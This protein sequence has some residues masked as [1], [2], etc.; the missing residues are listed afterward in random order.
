MLKQEFEQLA[1]RSVTDDQFKAINDLY[2]Q[3]DL[4]K[5][6]FVKSIKPLLATIKE[7]EKP[8]LSC[9]MIRHNSAG[10]TKTPNGCWYLTTKVQ[11]VDVDIRKGKVF[12]RKI[13]DSFEMVSG[14]YDEN[15]VFNDWDSRIV[16]V[17][18]AD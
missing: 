12:L 6:A 18:E 3:S 4:D 5:L 2:M 14:F 9:Y 13:P 7:I 16:F 10:E 15:P 1:R 8:I 17:D 11:I